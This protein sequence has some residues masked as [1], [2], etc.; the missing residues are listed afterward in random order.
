M[1]SLH[2]SN[3]ATMRMARP[4]G[5]DHQWQAR[6]L[7]H[8]LLIRGPRLR[9]QDRHAPE[10]GTPVVP[11]LIQCP[12]HPERYAAT[13]AAIME[14]LRDITPDIEIFSV[15]EAFL[16]ITHCQRL[17]GTPPH[18]A[19][20]RS[21]KYS[22]PPDSVFHWRQ[23]RQDHRQVCCQAEQA[24][25]PDHYPPWEAAERLHDVPV[26]SY[27]ALQQVSADSGPH[28]VYTCGEVKHLPVSVLARRFGNPGR[29]IWYMCQGQ[30]PDKCIRISR[31]RNPLAMAR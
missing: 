29:R 5:R 8:H 17:L 30:D 15:D 19:S 3:N 10:R 20:W 26:T 6:Q 9:H 12:A 4:S 22:M 31:H 18:I 11:G 13:S 2:L 14:A 27:A 21:R 23:R 25:W 16:D 7:H 1:P 24:G 28:G